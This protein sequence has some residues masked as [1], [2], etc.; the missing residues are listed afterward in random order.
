[1]KSAAPA[2]VRAG[3]VRTAVAASSAK[4]NGTTWGDADAVAAA[5]HRWKW[6]L[7]TQTLFGGIGSGSW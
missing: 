5:L 4:S 7:S 1:M 2:G 3:S 6:L